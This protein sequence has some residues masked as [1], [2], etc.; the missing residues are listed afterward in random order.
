MVF[1]KR[2][3]ERSLELYTDKFFYT[4]FE[5]YLDLKL[6]IIQF[7]NNIIQDHRNFIIYIVSVNFIVFF[8]FFCN[9]PHP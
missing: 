9:F 2:Y 7:Q 6:K 4:C 1:D 8:F 3:T 5:K